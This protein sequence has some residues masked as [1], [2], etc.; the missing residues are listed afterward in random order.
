[1]AKLNLKLFG[2][3]KH[4]KSRQRAPKFQFL[5]WRKSTWD[6]ENSIYICFSGWA[7]WQW[8]WYD[9]KPYGQVVNPGPVRVG[10]LEYNG[11]M[12]VVSFAAERNYVLSLYEQQEDRLEA[13][14][15]LNA[16]LDGQMDAMEVIAEFE[17][18]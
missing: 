18:G 6:P 11:L 1:M 9:D 14:H 7:F 10:F 12:T 3:D 8:S 16:Y 13:S 4:N 5:P 2:F 15:V 17:D